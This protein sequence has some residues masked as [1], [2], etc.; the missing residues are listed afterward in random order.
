MKKKNNGGFSLV[1]VLVSVTI[2]SIITTFVCTSM[3]RSAQI[4]AKSDAMLEARIAVSSAVEQLKASDITGESPEY[5][6]V[7]YG[8]TKEDLFPDVKVSTSEGTLSTYYIVE[9]SDNADLVKV[10]T[11]IR[12]AEGG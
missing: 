8:G 5:D 7:S 2:M 3:M 4:D 6:I 1:E 9:V 10:T 12:A 11:C